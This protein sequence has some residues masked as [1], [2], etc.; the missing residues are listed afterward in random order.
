MNTHSL[1]DANVL[2]A[3]LCL[4][5]VIYKT[6]FVVTDNGHKWE[7]DEYENENRGLIVAELE[8][9]NNRK[10]ISTPEWVGKEISDDDRYSNIS[11]VQ[12]PYSTWCAGPETSN[13][14]FYL[15]RSESIPEG[16]SR[17]L[18]EQLDHAIAAL[19]DSARP[20]SD[21]VHEARRSL[22][23][24]RSLLRLARPALADS[25]RSANQELRDIGRRLSDVRD[26]EVLTETCDRI[27][28]DT[29]R[30]VQAT[31]DRAKTRILGHREKIQEQFEDANGRAAM[32]QK[33]RAIQTRMAAW[34][35]NSVDKPTL[36]AGIEE[37]LRGGADAFSTAR[38]D[39]NDDTF[40]AWRK[41][42][43]DWRY[44]FEF[45]HK[46][47]PKVLSGYA[48]SAKKLE[49][50]LGEDHDLAVLR[51]FISTGPGS[52]RK[53][54]QLLVPVIQSEQEKLRKKSSEMGHVLYSDGPRRW[55]ERLERC[56]DTW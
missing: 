44:Q 52:H 19:S 24:A 42:A 37:M 46:L 41:R 56:W 38:E 7:I 47:W 39:P 11:L 36:L 49:Q 30:P 10:H 25:Y 17:S 31:I 35:L 4:K 23:K 20:A 29:P 14:E 26:I 48:K 9:T 22:K 18:H 50:K 8:L 15:K 43:K 27:K 2:L 5:P 3:E 32:R 34:P 13:P 55:A 21:A 33:L 51:G 16:V 1:K 28:Q 12:H 54:A 40:H 53:D 6:R 45:L